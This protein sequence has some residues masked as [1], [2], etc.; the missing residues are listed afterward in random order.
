MFKH[1]LT[2]RGNHHRLVGVWHG[3]VMRCTNPNWINYKDYGGRGIKVCERWRKLANFVEDMG[4][5]FIE[6]L[7][8]DRKE[9]DGDYCPEN[10][11]WETKVNQQNNR[12]SNRF[13]THNGETM[14]VAQWERKLGVKKCILVS[15][16]HRGWSVEKTL[17]HNLDA[18][19]KSVA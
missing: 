6:G 18:L 5:S 7:W 4:P 11:R 13:L 9:N 12:R 17:T 2:R 15:R 10:C 19:Q 3:M 16:L 14:T 8:L 1:G